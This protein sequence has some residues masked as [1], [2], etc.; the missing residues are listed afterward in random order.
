MAVFK[1][2][3]VPINPTA[4]IAQYGNSDPVTSAI[5]GGVKVA[6]TPT[7]VV[8]LFGPDLILFFGYPYGH[9]T[10]GNFT[11]N[12]QVQI[13]VTNVNIDIVTLAP[14]LSNP[15]AAIP[16]VLGGNDTIIGANVVGIDHLRASSGNDT[17]QGRLGKDIVDGGTG[18]DTAIYS[19][20]TAGIALAL[21]DGTVN[22]QS[23]HRRHRR[24]RRQRGHQPGQ[25]RG[26]RQQYRE[27]HR[28]QRQRLPHRQ[29]GGK[30]PQ[31]AMPATI[32]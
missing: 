31:L 22:R 13:S 32:R 14:F 26:L 12:G 20:K 9:V 28:R 16:V 19:E 18:V 11:V 2:D 6:L 24:A 27:R 15:L 30:C 3:F 1:A 7:A 4:L 25:A 8:N 17:I 10:S 29:C 23:V 21:K 5:T